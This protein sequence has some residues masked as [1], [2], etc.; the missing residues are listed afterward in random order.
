MIPVP[1]RRASATII[2]NG[3][4]ITT[5]LDDKT[6]SFTYNDPETGSSDDISLSIQDP[7]DMWING[8][9]PRLGDKISALIRVNDWRMPGDNRFLNCGE[10]VID[11]PGF[12]GPPTKVDFKAVSKPSDQSF[13]T[14]KRTKVWENVTLFQIATEISSRYAMLLEY[15]ADSIDIDSLEQSDVT[16]S[17]F[18]NQTCQ[19]Y[20]L[21]CKIY[22]HKLVIFDRQKMMQMPPVA[23][24]DRG[25]MEQWSY[26][27]TLSGTYTGGKMTYSDADSGEDVEASCGTTERLL[28]VNGK[29]DNQADA[30]KQIKASVN[31]ANEDAE[32][33]SITIPGDPDR[34]SSQ[35]VLITGL[36]VANG[37]YYTKKVTHSLGSKYSTKLELSKIQPQL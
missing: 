1:V 24:I 2:Y 23:V 16:D 11:D 10:F 20:N 15:I 19:T 35:C 4:N 13:D 6:G 36:G 7:H 37:K 29:A 5:T 34:C 18:M 28:S 26:K 12:S 22:S 25:S 3:E 21:S 30:E 27:T 17:D 8:M 33:L 14:Q 32:T 31:E 9:F